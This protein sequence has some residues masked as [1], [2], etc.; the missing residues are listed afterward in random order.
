MEQSSN[1]FKSCKTSTICKATANA[2]SDKQIQFGEKSNTI[3]L[4]HSS[5][6]FYKKKIIFKLLK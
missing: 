1:N 3:E 6:T 2:G 4:S 5:N